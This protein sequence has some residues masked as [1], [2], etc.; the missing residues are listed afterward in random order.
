MDNRNTVGWIY[1]PEH[2]ENG[3]IIETQSI[4]GEEFAHIWLPSS[5]KVVRVALKNLKPAAE[6][7]NFTSDYITYLVNAA[8]VSEVK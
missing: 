7:R 4:W 3:K 5:N 8:R 6:A 2:N 1:S